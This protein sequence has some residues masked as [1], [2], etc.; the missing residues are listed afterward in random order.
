MRKDSTTAKLTKYERERNK[1][2]SKVRYIVEQYFGISHLHDKAKRARFTTISKNKFDA[3][4]R[5]SPDL[6]IG[7]LGI[8]GPYPRNILGEGIIHLYLEHNA[9]LNPLSA[10][11]PLMRNWD[12]AGRKASETAMLLHTSDES[13]KTFNF[14]L[15]K[16]FRDHKIDAVF[17]SNWHPKDGDSE[18]GINTVFSS[19]GFDFKKQDLVLKLINLTSRDRKITMQLGNIDTNAKAEMIVL[20]A[21]PKQFNTPDSPDSIKPE[22]RL[23][24]VA[25]QGELSLSPRSLTIIRI[26]KAELANAIE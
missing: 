14:H 23:T 11:R 3:Y 25:T 12:F 17:P 5:P 20:T 16:L 10:D 8:D 26:P 13:I 6:F 18:V 4:E 7:E 1:R 21:G 19:A 9:D 22:T 24:E 15:S 2:I